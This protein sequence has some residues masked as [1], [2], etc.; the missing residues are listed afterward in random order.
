MRKFTWRGFVCLSLLYRCKNNLFVFTSIL[1]NACNNKSFITPRP[2]KKIEWESASQWTSTPHLCSWNYG[3]SDQEKGWQNAQVPTSITPWISQPNREIQICF[4][5]KIKLSSLEEKWWCNFLLSPGSQEILINMLITSL[6]QGIWINQKE[7]VFRFKSHPFMEKGPFSILVQS[8]SRYKFR[9]ICRGCEAGVDSLLKGNIH[10]TK[11]YIW[12]RRH[13][14]NRI[15]PLNLIKSIFGKK[16]PC[17]SKFILRGTFLPSNI[18]IK[19]IPQVPDIMEIREIRRA[20]DLSL[21][22]EKV[23][24]KIHGSGQKDQPH[25]LQLLQVLQL[26]WPSQ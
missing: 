8:F 20:S 6:L 16:W 14:I 17:K 26:P 1:W 24:I 2:E 12:Q 21:A 9:R 10:S 15:K 23:C 5:V 25:F 18:F 13:E 19:E 4:K 7:G 3:S 11:R 22:Q